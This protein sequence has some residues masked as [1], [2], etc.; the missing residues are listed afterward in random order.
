VRVRLIK[1]TV[2]DSTYSDDQGIYRFY[3]V[4]PDTYTVVGTVNIEG[5]IYRGQA[6]VTVTAPGSTVEVDLLLERQ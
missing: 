6:S 4:S 1:G 5:V 2:V 3:D